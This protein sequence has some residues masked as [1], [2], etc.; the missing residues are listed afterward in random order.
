M[1]INWISFRSEKNTF[2][3]GEIQKA[4]TFVESRGLRKTRIFQ[5]QK[6]R[7][8]AAFI[9]R[10]KSR[11]FLQKA[12]ASGGF[13]DRKFQSCNLSPFHTSTPINTPLRPHFRLIRVRGAPQAQFGASKLGNYLYKHLLICISSRIE[14]CTILVLDCKSIEDQLGTLA[15]FVPATYVRSFQLSLMDL[16]GFC[17]FLSFISRSMSQ[18]LRSRDDLLFYELVLLRMFYLIFALIM[19]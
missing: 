8:A 15:I 11:G 5:S 17:S 7:K 1:E 6:R 16:C 10:T 14:I 13:C 18:F 4:A 2:G 12:A 3:A 9:R 19:S